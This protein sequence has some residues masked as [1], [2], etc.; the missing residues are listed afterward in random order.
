MRLRIIDVPDIF[1]PSCKIINPPHQKDSLMI[2]EKAFN[3]FKKKNI[4]S[5]YIYVPISWT[6]YHV[7]N[8]FGK[9]VRDLSNFCNSLIKKYPNDKFFTIVQYD[10][11]ILVPFDNC[12]IFACS[13][14]FNSPKGI[15]S[16]YI[17][18][19]LLSD[20]HNFKPTKKKFLAAFSGNFQ[21]HPIRDKMFNTLSSEKGFKFSKP[22]RYFNNY[23]YKKNMLSSIFA[24]CPRGYG[25]ASFR[26]YEALQMK[27]IPVYISDE[28]WLPYKDQIDWAKVAILV[29]END[30]DQIPKII[31]NLIDTSEYRKILDYTNSIYDSYFT[32]ESCLNQIE[33]KIC[34]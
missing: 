1:R 30:I 11:G 7:N 6:A 21:T 23:F 14:S 10:G 12:T 9:E 4:D 24:L 27:L 33:K 16:N 25:P 19:P 5:D 31:K 32:W 34:S 8:N 13:G 2:E 3:Y 29:K 28:F 20:P 22:S 15:N 18:I 17:P 26:M